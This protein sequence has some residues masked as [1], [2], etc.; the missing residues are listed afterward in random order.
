MVLTASSMEQFSK[1]KWLDIKLDDNL[2]YMLIKSRVFSDLT[3]YSLLERNVVPRHL[4]VQFINEQNTEQ[5][6]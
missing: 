6:N 3:Y 1:M 2:R 5:I 4:F